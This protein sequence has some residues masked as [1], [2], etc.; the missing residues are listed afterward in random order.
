MG[1]GQLKQNIV[2]RPYEFI[3]I[4][5]YPQPGNI[6]LYCTS[7]VGLRITIIR[8]DGIGLV[9]K[10]ERVFVCARWRRGVGRC[11]CNRCRRTVI[12]TNSTDASA[13]IVCRRTRSQVCLDDSPHLSHTDGEQ[14]HSIRNLHPLLVLISALVKLRVSSGTNTSWIQS[15]AFAIVIAPF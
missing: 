2:C 9:I 10:A 7:T 13:P 5:V 14:S 8:R 3:A 11:R 15:A 4:V 12:I 1:G 6:I